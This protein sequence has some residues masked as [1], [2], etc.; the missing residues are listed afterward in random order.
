MAGDGSKGRGAAPKRTVAGYCLGALG[1]DEVRRD[2]ARTYIALGFEDTDGARPPVTIGL[3]LEAKKSESKETVL[4][5]FVAV[6]KILRAEDFIE[7]RQGRRYPAQ[8]D[9]VRANVVA[10]VGSDNFVNH[11]D[12]PGDHVREYMRHLVPHLSYTGEQNAT[13]LQKAI[14][15]AMALK[16][17]QTATE[18]VRGFILEENPIRVSELREVHPD[19]QKHQRHDPD[20]AP[21]A[22]SAQ[23]A[24]ERVG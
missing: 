9:D 23:G 8:W 2:E 16:Q 7:I 13:A 14:V 17:N 19:L 15:N 18:F 24:S 6:G 21:E 10:A 3:A 1:D 22:R 12:K 5:R 11:R 4:A 20:D